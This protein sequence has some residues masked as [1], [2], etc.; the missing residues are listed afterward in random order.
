MDR[1]HPA[2]RLHPP[3]ELAPVRAPFLAERGRGEPR[4]VEI[5]ALRRPLVIDAA[6][7]AAGGAMRAPDPLR[8]GEG[9]DGTSLQ[10]SEQSPQLRPDTSETVS[11][12]PSAILRLRF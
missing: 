11:V 7:R 2:V 1:D 8:L 6:S 5:A 10:H 4:A 3:D 9:I 12:L